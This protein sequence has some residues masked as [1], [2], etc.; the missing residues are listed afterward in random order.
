MWQA[1][2]LDL[3][4]TVSLIGN[5]HRCTIILKSHVFG[6][7]LDSNSLNY[8]RVIIRL[9][10]ANA[11]AEGSTHDPYAWLTATIQHNNQK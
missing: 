7:S 1:G 8:R 9:S 6:P 11:M 3:I 10:T 2:G 4:L 5:F